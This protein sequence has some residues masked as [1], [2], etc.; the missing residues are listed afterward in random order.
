MFNFS[1]FLNYFFLTFCFILKKIF[2]L[3]IFD[4]YK[5]KKNVKKK[6]K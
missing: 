5:K 1:E 4:L 3:F 2:K 6:K